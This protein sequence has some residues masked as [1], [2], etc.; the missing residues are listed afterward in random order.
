MI[1]KLLFTA[2]LLVPGATYAANPSGSLSDQVVSA[3]PVIAAV[4]ACAI[5][6]NYTGSIPAPAQA[7]GYTTCA[8][9]YDW[10]STA[11]FTPTGLAGNNAL[12]GHT[13]NLSNTATWLVCG[14][15]ST[16]IGSALFKQQT[17][18]CGAGRVSI[19]RDDAADGLNSLQMLFTLTDFNK[20]IGYLQ[21]SSQD[22]C[23]N[24]CDAA[25]TTFPTG[26]Y[27]EAV[28][29]VPSQSVPTEFA[30]L[31]GAAFEDSYNNIQ[32]GKSYLET[33]LFELYIPDHSNGGGC[34]EW[35][36]TH[37][38]LPAGTPYSN[39]SYDP[40]VYNTYGVRITQNESGML[41]ECFYWNGA[42]VPSSGGRKPC[43]EMVYANGSTSDSISAR[44]QLLLWSGSG[45]NT[46]C[47]TPCTRTP[48]AGG[49]TINY[50][51]ITY[52]TCSTWETKG[53]TG[54]VLSSP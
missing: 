54:T 33:D 30:S 51:R 20:N 39:G 36:P 53:C 6:P 7:A 11:N 45:S 21:L 12:N 50:R 42:A 52:W 47:G 40:T 48:G 25:G 29:R 49:I 32:N 1:K 24:P 9:N 27:I 14:E 15:P 35:N 22:N 26:A 8:A 10:S 28:M 34:L 38:C 16:A 43:V 3:V 5:G 31:V 2:A 23:V 37:N 13:Y 17:D 44:N 41:A 18:P 19:V 4:T 46:S